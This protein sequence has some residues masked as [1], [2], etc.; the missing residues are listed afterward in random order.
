MGHAR[1]WRVSVPSLA[2]GSTMLLALSEEKLTC[3]NNRHTYPSVLWSMHAQKEHLHFAPFPYLADIGDKASLWWENEEVEFATVS[4][5]SVGSFAY[6]ATA[7]VGVS[8]V[9][10]TTGMRVAHA[11]ASLDFEE[12]PILYYSYDTSGFND[13]V[14]YNVDGQW[15]WATLNQIRDNYPAYIPKE[16]GSLIQP[17]RTSLEW[18]KTRALTIGNGSPPLS[19]P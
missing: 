15:S 7:A 17:R 4:D 14:T 1:M 11:P 18:L 8:F 6:S 3:S 10:N 9:T 16:E 13:S 12:F 5:Y 2:S 19:Q